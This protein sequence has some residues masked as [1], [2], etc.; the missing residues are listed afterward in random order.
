M[1][2]MPHINKSPAVGL[3]IVGL[4]VAVGVATVLHHNP[5]GAVDASVLEWM[6]SHRSSGG[7]TVIAGVT[8]LFGPV[9][10][11]A[12]TA[13]AAV[14]FILFDRNAVRAITVVAS[15]AVAGA[16][17]AILKL[18]FDRTR[19][20]FVDQAATFE[21]S[22]SFPSGHVTGTTALV[23]GLALAVTVGMTRRS[24]I[25]AIVIAMVVAAFAA[26]TRLYLGLHWFSDI[27]AGIAVGA[28]AAIAVPSVVVAV[29]VAL[30][31]HL[32]QRTRPYLYPPT[33]LYPPTNP[34]PPT[35]FGHPEQP[36]EGRHS[37][38]VAS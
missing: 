3:V 27:L 38:P 7:I 33:S 24:R 23:L 17:G 19:P 11:V 8:G 29:L 9:W 30:G 35:S 15:V 36:Q 5:F 31:P 34:S 13:I 25:A 16:L 10:V 28:A 1:F 26:L 14:A 2:V 20:P 12:W 37:A 6:V 18:V 22:Q 4:V 32:P 21:A